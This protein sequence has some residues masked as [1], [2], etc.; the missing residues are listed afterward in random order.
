M[1][2]LINIF[3]RA[4]EIYKQIFEN[5]KR[6]FCTHS[7]RCMVAGGLFFQPFKNPLYATIAI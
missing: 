3:K 6:T 5:K 2:I 7:K 4:T 1:Y